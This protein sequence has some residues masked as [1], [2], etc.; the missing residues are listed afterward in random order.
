METEKP[1]ELVAYLD[2]T[3]CPSA[4]GGDP[5]K[6]M[7]HMIMMKNKDVA[8]RE[9]MWDETRVST[10]FFQS[11]KVG[12]SPPLWS[13]PDQGY[14]P[15]CVTEKDKRARASLSLTLGVPLR[16]IAGAEL[17]GLFAGHRY[18]N[19]STP[20]GWRPPAPPRDPESNMTLLV[21]LLRRRPPAPVDEGREGA[22][23][24]MATRPVPSTPGPGGTLQ[25]KTV[26]DT[27]SDCTPAT[28]SRST[29]R[30]EG[31]REGV[32]VRSA[33]VGEKGGK[34]VQPCCGMVFERAIFIC[35]H[36]GGGAHARTG[37]EARTKETRKPKAKDQ[38]IDMLSSVHAVHPPV[39]TP[40]PNVP[41]PNRC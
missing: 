14:H 22:S 26:C 16:L 41:E 9:R 10:P 11:P 24:R 20:P 2:V 5:Q 36:R 18:S 35:T 30:G 23:T 33:A 21:L 40:H 17:D 39:H 12:L 31:R 34:H 6:N 13:S 4:G 28:R 1:R 8:G 29:R 25:R 7:E 15:F 19:T 27:I 3:G 37:C 32:G 38:S